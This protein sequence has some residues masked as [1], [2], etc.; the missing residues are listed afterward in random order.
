M[1]TPL[2]TAA[3]SCTAGDTLL[4]VAANLTSYSVQLASSPWLEHGDVAIHAGGDPGTWFSASDGSLTPLAAT[5]HSGLDN[6][7]GSWQSLNI[8]WAGAPAPLHTRFICWL[9]ADLLEGRA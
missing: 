4:T 2:L 3:W 5:A 7:L 9:Y 8:S 1:L 6:L